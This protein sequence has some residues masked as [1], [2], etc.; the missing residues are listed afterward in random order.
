MSQKGEL[1]CISN[2]A[3]T[4]FM[5]LKSSDIFSHVRASLRHRLIEQWL[6][7]KDVLLLGLLRLLAFH[8]L[9]GCFDEKEAKEYDGQALDDDE[10]LHDLAR[11]RLLV[12]QSLYLFFILRCFLGSHYHSAQNLVT[13]IFIAN[14]MSLRH[15]NRM[16]LQAV[17]MSIFLTDI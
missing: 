9:L 14:S 11:R 7:Y 2:Y 5:A 17:N 13:V 6:R 16:T 15:Y 1:F 3:Q 10:A 8:S 4:I 12:V